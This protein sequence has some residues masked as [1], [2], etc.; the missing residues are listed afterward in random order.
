MRAF[1]P[2]VICLLAFRWLLWMRGFE[3]S[4]RKRT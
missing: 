3:R 1:L 4:H 2:I